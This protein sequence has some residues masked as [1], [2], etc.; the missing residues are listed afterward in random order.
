MMLKEVSYLSVLATV[1][2]L[3]QFDVSN[4]VKAPEDFRN[5]HGKLTEWTHGRMEEFRVSIE[6]SGIVRVR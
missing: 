4:S 5:S 1:A 3:M 2:P 6:V